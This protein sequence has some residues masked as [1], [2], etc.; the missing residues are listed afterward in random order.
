MTALALRMDKRITLQAPANSKNEIGED[1]A[2]WTNFVT[3]GDGKTWASIVDISGREFIAA[4]AVQTSAQTKIT[5]R[6]LAGVVP[7]MRVLYGAAVYNIEAVLDKDRRTR[8]LMCS[9]MP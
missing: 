6:Y 5:L 2:G 9:R 1:I 4:S 8:L 3:E 7:S